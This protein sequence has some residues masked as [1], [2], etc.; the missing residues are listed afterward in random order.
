M[1]VHV[2]CICPQIEFRENNSEPLPEKALTAQIHFNVKL[3]CCCFECEVVVISLHIY[4]ILELDGFIFTVSLY[5]K[6]VG[7]LTSIEY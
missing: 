2:T 5:L 3:L 7:V 6:V 1:Y 4:S